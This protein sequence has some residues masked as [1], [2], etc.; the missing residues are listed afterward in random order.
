MK[1]D[2]NYAI[3]SKS[4]LTMKGQIYD[5]NPFPHREI[6]QIRT[7]FSVPY[8]EVSPFPIESYLQLRTLRTLF[9]V[10]PI[11]RPHIES[12]RKRCPKCPKLEIAL[13]RERR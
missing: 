10:P 7:L 4:G 8:I 11:E 12:I 1:I 2:T 6:S 9:N 5:T 3:T 13:Y